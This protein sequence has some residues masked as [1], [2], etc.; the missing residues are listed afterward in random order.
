MQFA[1]FGKSERQE[2]IERN[3]VRRWLAQ[4]GVTPPSRLPESLPLCYQHRFRR[5]PG[6]AIPLPTDPLADFEQRLHVGRVE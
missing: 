6:P 4:R 1:H 5:R 2:R 3:G